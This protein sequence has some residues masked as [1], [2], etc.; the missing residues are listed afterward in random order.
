MGKRAVFR[1]FIRLS[2]FRNSGKAAIQTDR[3]TFS[4]SSLLR[5]LSFTVLYF[6]QGIP[7]GFLYLAMPAWMATQDYTPYQIGK[8]LA[9]SF[10]PW[11]LKILAAPIMDRYSYL[12]MGRRHPWILAGQ[13]GIVLGMLLMSLVPHPESRLN[14][15]L[16]MGFLI[17]LFTIIQDI[18]IDG[19]AIDL[20]PPEQQ[21]RAN[22]LM[23]GAK[24]IGVSATVALTAFLFHRVGFAGTLWLFAGL[25]VLLM[26]LPLIFRERPGEKLLPWLRGSVSPDVLRLQV[27]G[28]HIVGRKLTGLLVLRSSLLF[29]LGIFLYSVVEGIVDATVPVMA[30]QELGWTDEQ[31]SGILSVSQLL[32]GLLGMF[33]GGYLIDRFG[34]KHMLMIILFSLVIVLGAFAG[35]PSFWPQVPFFTGFI[36]VYCLLRT[37][38]NIAFFALAMQFCWKKMAATQFTVYMTLMN[39]GMSL[40]SYL[41]GVFEQ[42]MIWEWV[43]AVNIAILLVNILALRYT[44]LRAYFW[45]MKAVLGQREE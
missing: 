27:P 29:G 35:L 37:F 20:L 7:Q 21:A 13:T 11:S 42:I 40:G 36:F 31:Y 43:F 45:G 8:F 38:V 28:W 15:L 18:A 44:D 23:W 24:T 34:K 5:Y 17:N 22:G 6:A 2:K 39:L 41:M 33:T 12:A 1:N 26:I 32:G 14:L 9:I 4:G 3:L 25:V 30:V 10:L 16:L 19:L